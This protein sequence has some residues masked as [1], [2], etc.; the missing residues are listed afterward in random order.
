VSRP[1]RHETEQSPAECLR[2][3]DPPTQPDPGGPAGEVMGHDLD[4]RRTLRCW[5]I[6]IE[7]R[8]SILRQTATTSEA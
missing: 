8:T 7:K 3:D 5:R 2:R 4:R 6:V 1:A